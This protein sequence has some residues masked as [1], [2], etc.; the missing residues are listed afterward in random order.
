[1]QGKIGKLSEGKVSHI[2][3]RDSK[4]THLLQS[5]L[6][7]HDHVSLICTITLASSNMEEIHNTLKFA[8]RAKRVEICAAANRIID[9]NSLIKKYQKE[10]S[11]LKNELDQL[12]RGILVT[13][14]HE[15]L[16]TLRQQLETGQAKM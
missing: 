2:P 13:P 6:S 1:M 7:G 12:K 4:L 8:Q 5:S 16:L 14:S 9:K 15:E 11:S 3:Y 10:I